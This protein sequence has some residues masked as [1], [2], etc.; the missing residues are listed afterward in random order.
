MKK[1]FIFY[2]DVLSKAWC[3]Y[4]EEIEIENDNYSDA[5]N[6]AIIKLSNKYAIPLD[7]ELKSFQIKVY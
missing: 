3:V 7:I 1:T 5:L 2:F 6:E 4:K